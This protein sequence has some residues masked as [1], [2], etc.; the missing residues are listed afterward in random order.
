MSPP[1]VLNREQGTGNSRLLLNTLYEIP[2]H[3]KIK[4]RLNWDSK[5]TYH[6]C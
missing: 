3:P 4:L 5:P 6:R 1:F 2:A